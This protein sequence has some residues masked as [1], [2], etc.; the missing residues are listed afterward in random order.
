MSDDFIRKHCHGS[1]HRRS[2]PCKSIDVTATLRRSGRY[3]GEIWF[4]DE[5]NPHFLLDTAALASTIKA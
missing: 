3:G 4:G 1:S 2:H 5:K